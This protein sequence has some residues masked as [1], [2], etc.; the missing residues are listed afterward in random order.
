[1][2]RLGHRCHNGGDHAHG[3]DDPCCQDELAHG[4]AAYRA[5]SIGPP[6]RRSTR[7][8]FRCLAAPSP[9]AASYDATDSGLPRLVGLLAANAASRGTWGGRG[10]SKVRHLPWQGMLQ[11]SPQRRYSA[12]VPTA[13]LTDHT[14]TTPGSHPKQPAGD[15]ARTRDPYLGKVMLLICI[16]GSREE[17]LGVC[18]ATLFGGDLGG[19]RAAKGQRLG[20]ARAAMRRLR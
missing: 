18:W 3:D 2:Q 5:G 1:M 19:G 8:R 13:V 14:E 16:R 10:R 15:E 9:E 7:F 4:R 17:G 12:E 6:A 20:W 11:L